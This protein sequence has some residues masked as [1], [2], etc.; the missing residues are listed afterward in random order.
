MIQQIPELKSIEERQIKVVF[1]LP[2]D[3]GLMGSGNTIQLSER[4]IEM[5]DGS[6]ITILKYN[7]ILAEAK[8][9]Y[10]EHIDYQKKANI[11]P[12]LNTKA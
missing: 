9:M 8:K 11:V 5:L 2:E 7:K 1:I 12:I 6:N 4:E 10:R 3:T